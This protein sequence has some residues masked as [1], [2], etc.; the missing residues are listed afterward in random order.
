MSVRRFFRRR[1]WDDERAREIRAHLA[2]EIDDLIARGMRPRDAHDAAVRKFG[3]PTRIREEIYD[4]NSVSWFEAV[5]LDIRDAWRQLRRRRATAAGAVL[6][7]ATGIAASTAAFAV[8]RGVL[9]DALPYPDAARLV[10]LWQVSDRQQTQLSYPDLQDLRSLPV[11]DDTAAIGSGIGTL[12]RGDDVDRVM[13][14][15]GEAALMPMLGARAELG[16]LPQASDASRPVAAISHRLWERVYH[17]DPAV[18]GQ[19]FELSGRRY[20]II[21]VVAPLS[22]ELPVGAPGPGATF[23]IKDVDLWAALDTTEQMAQSRAISTYEALARLAP[24]VTLARAQSALDARGRALAAQFAD[25]NRDR[26]FRAVPLQEQIVGPQAT[27]IWI[28]LGGALLMLVIACVNAASLA[29]GELPQRRQDF[30]LREALGA[31]RL[32]LLRQIVWESAFVALAAAAAGIG[33]AFLIVARVTAALELPRIGAVRIDGG[34]AAVAAAAALLS[35]LLA[36][37]LP[38]A[39]LDGGAAG[40]RGSA[41]SHSAGAARVRRALV[42]AQVALALALCGAGALLAT[43]LRTVLRV[44]PGFDRSSALT[45]RLSAYPAAYPAKSDVVRFFDELTGRLL[46]H[47]E[48]VAA[49]ASMSVPLGGI[50]HGHLRAG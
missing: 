3:S 32:R 7:L 49:G 43:S 17:R 36:R 26:G 45:A 19:S 42:T 6:L 47:P 10:T 20:D 2:H 27:A 25:T 28:A 11:F 34:V 15:S 31:G 24:G 12:V 8:A 21:G 13:M 48:A 38:L 5:R 35:A 23:T 29:L 39:G 14:V 40:L 16:R 33:G 37:A 18:V 41:S 9:L 30:A 1:Q 46:R 50:Q 4:S 22:F 44:D